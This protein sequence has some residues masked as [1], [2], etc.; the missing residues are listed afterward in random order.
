MC[1]INVQKVNSNY[2][3]F[4]AIQVWQNLRDFGV[5]KSCTIHTF[6]CQIFI[7][8]QP[9]S[10]Y[11]ARLLNTLVTIFEFFWIFENF[12]MLFTN[13]LRNE[14]CVALWL[15][16]WFLFDVGFF[17]RHGLS[18]MIG[19]TELSPT[20]PVTFSPSSSATFLFSSVHPETWT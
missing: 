13:F 2:I 20:K 9:M 16:L 14:I 17:T 10:C 5:L 12:N 6:R 19:Q 11:F 4:L 18:F 7:F 1:S 8:A 15:H 3:V